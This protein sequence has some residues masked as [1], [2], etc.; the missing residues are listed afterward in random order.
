MF[1]KKRLRSCISVFL[2]VLIFLL[3]L[4]ISAWAAISDGGKVTVEKPFIANSP[5]YEA[6]VPILNANGAV[7]GIRYDWAGAWQRF[8]AAGTG[9]V[10]YCVQFGEKIDSGKYTAMKADL[11]SYFRLLSKAAK[12]GITYTSIYGFPNLKYGVSDDK[13][14]LATQAIIWEFQTGLRTSAGTTDTNGLKDYVLTSELSL[15]DGNRAPAEWGNPAYQK[16]TLPKDL[17]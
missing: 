17:F 2:A 15:G 6:A 8:S 14:W 7:I 13:A 1:K 4:P 11:N 3:M 10:L 9:D 16:A 12:D 5:H